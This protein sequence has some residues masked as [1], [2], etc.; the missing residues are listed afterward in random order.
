MFINMRNIEYLFVRA[1]CI[2]VWI[3]YLQ[4]YSLLVL[5]ILFSVIKAAIKV[6]NDVM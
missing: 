1:A 6:G 3:Q 4:P 2:F 5:C